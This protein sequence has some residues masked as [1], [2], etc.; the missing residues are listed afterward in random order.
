MSYTSI[1]ARPGSGSDPV[2]AMDLISSVN[3][4][5]GKICLGGVGSA[6]DL[7]MGQTTK[8][9]SMPVSLASD[10][11]TPGLPTSLAV[12]II[13]GSTTAFKIGAGVAGVAVTGRQSITIKNSTAVVLY[14]FTDN[15]LTSSTGF[16]IAANGSV[17]IHV[18]EVQQIW[19]LLASGTGSIP[20]WEEVK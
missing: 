19:G 8:A 9:A 10:Q 17:T 7:G 4:P 2:L 12:K 5:R 11:E 14:W 3:F 20:C 6:T 1:A 18:S 15:T 13:A 16:P